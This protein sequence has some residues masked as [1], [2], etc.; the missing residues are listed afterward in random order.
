[1]SIN[2]DLPDR[3]DWGVPNGDGENTEE[4]DCGDAVNDDFLAGITNGIGASDDAGDSGS[5]L[6][7]TGTGLLAARGGELRDGDD[8]V[9]DGRSGEVRK[10]GSNC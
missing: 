7:S 6:S 4:P 10:G 1:M 2:R 5:G 9:P 8:D 3:A